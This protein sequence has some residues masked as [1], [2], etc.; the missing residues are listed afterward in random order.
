MTT[1]EFHLRATSFGGVAD[2]Y[3]RTRPGYPD[4]AVRWLTGDRPVRVLDLG[5]GTGKLTRSLV[6][7]GHDVVAVDPSEPMLARLRAALPDVDARAGSAE[8]LPLDDATVDVVTAGQAYHW[9]DPASALPEIAR[10]LRH[11]GRLGLVWNLRD[12]SVG[13]V[14]ELWS[15]FGD[16]EV[17]RADDP[18]VIPPFGPVEQRTFRHEQRLDRDG[19]LGLVASRSYIAI[20]AAPQRDAVLARVGALYD[21]VAG[22]DGL[23]L[24]YLTHCFRSM[25]G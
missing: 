24:P 10:V 9:F 5:A 6:S 11:G 1:D 14:D 12:D 18:Q 20:L 7:A 8:R 19:L 15:M 25:R 3:E 16:H 17:R 22:P 21:R 4:E 2:L 23:V 13:W